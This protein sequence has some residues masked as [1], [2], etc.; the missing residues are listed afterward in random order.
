MLPKKFVFMLGALALLG[1]EQAF[2]YNL[3]KCGNK[4]LNWAGNQYHTRA[5]AVGFPA[6]PWRNALADVV[7]HWNKNPS[8]LR[9]SIQWNEPGVG[10]G[11]GQN[12]VWW[13]SGFGAPAIANWWYNI[14]SCKFNEVD[15]RFDNTVAYHYTQNK[16]QL[17]PYG[18]SYRPFQ[19]TAMHEFGHAGG[20]GHEADT[21]NIMGQDWD[22][23][24]ANGSTAR[25]YA[26]EDASAGMVASYGKTG[27][28]R[29]DLGVVHWRYDEDT[30][31]QYSWHERTRILTTAN[32]EHAKVAGTKEPTYWVS[33][34][35]RFK[36]ELS[37]ENNGKS[38]KRVKVCYYL[39]TNDYISTFDTL[40]ATRMITVNP[41]GDPWGVWTSQYTLTLPKNL[42]GLK[43]YWVGAKIDCDSKVSETYEWNNATYV[44]IRTPFQLP[45]F[46]IGTLDRDIVRTPIAINGIR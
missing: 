3:L 45:T 41:N 19:T 4:N 37:F 32:V 27:G 22:H 8:K 29:E 33:P 43:N 13:T 9:Y 6:G 7:N 14:N 42:P 5:S 30:S 12:E 34:G 25:A 46:P 40:L 36:L 18:G 17:K 10:M 2:A 28:Y 39:S 26:G 16:S 21:Y 20:L 35:K 1:V 44:G 31:G 23:I 24:H 11:N 15:I 38:S